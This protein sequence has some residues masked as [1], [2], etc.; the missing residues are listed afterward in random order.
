[1]CS[2]TKNLIVK[3]KL[4]YAK[5]EKPDVGC[6]LCSI[7]DNDPR[8]Q[9]L[10]IYRSQSFLITLNLFP[11]NPGH[12]MIFPIRHIV[13]VRDFTDSEWLELKKLQ[14][15]VLTLLNKEYGAESFNIGVN[16]GEFSGA[17]IE[18]IHY[19][20]VPRYKNEIGIVEIL[21]GTKILVESPDKTVEKLRKSIKKLIKNEK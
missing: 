5:G 16:Q 3:D 10:E 21:S 19:H 6:I 2:F 18:H 12:V 20:L 13:D 14:N 11:Y 9:S 4:R 7:R 1:M 15:T 8:V 17:S